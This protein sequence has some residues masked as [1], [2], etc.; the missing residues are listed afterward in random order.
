MIKDLIE[1][2][3]L[4]YYKEPIDKVDQSSIIELDHKDNTI[5]NVAVGNH[6]SLGIEYLG[7]Y[8]SMVNDKWPKIFIDQ[9]RLKKFINY[10]ILKYSNEGK[11]ES[12]KVLLIIS[13]TAY[14]IYN[15]CRFKFHLDLQDRLYG[16]PNRDQEIENTIAAAFCYLSLTRGISHNT[17]NGATFLFEPRPVM[18]WK[19]IK[20]IKSFSRNE[21]VDFQEKYV[22]EAISLLRSDDQWFDKTENF[23]GHLLNL[24]D[25]DKYK[26]LY[27]NNGIPINELVMLDLS[28]SYKINIDIKVLNFQIYDY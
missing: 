23:I 11:L 22:K 2:L 9:P 5:E 4:E 17:K 15:Y 8:Q 12:W 10:Q 13:S 21:I 14:L 1:K 16:I 27:Q 3:Y 25:R 24:L 7:H 26:E 18:M 28:S 19:Y 6:E 20:N